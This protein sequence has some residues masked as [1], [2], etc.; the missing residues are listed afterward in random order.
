MYGKEANTEHDPVPGYAFQEK[1]PGLL[2]IMPLPQASQTGR[3]VG[4]HAFHAGVWVSLSVVRQRT[5][6]K[7]L[8]EVVLGLS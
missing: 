5:A 6:F 3:A 8:T 2:L 1:L 7:E 4:T